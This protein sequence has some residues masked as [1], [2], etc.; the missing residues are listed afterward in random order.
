MYLQNLKN[1]ILNGIYPLG[2]SDLH[3]LF[4]NNSSIVNNTWRAIQLQSMKID[5]NNRQDSF[6]IHCRIP[7]FFNPKWKIQVLRMT[8]FSSILQNS[9]L[10]EET[11]MLNPSLSP[12]VA[13][14]LLSG[15]VSLCFL[16]SPLQL[17]FQRSLKLNHRS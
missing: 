9:D 12:Y 8:L 17:Q 10:M 3:S 4:Y 13:S 11:I 6:P 5:I 2:F 15:T 7:M 14:K 16:W 1:I